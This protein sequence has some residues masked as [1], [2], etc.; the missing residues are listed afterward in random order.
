M[1]EIIDNRAH[2]IRTVK[3]II[4]HL[5]QGGDPAEVAESRKEAEKAFDAFLENEGEEYRL[6]TE[7]EWEYACRAGT[8]TR[9]CFGDDERMLAHYAWWGASSGGR[10]HRVRQKK[11]NAWGLHD[12]HG[13]GWEWCADWHE[14]DPSSKRFTIPARRSYDR[15]PID[16]PT[17]P[18][19]GMFRVQRSCGC[20]YHRPDLYRCAARR[21]ARPDE[22]T[23]GFGFRVARTLTP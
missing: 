12:M 4:R 22:R 6:P 9:F 13:N 23:C 17:G 19:S 5:H 18:T 16:D 7:A 1:T 10:T 2:R 8:T 11:P 15:A 14:E 20:T 3:E 21:C